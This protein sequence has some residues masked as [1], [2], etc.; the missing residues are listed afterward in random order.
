MS[1]LDAT[2]AERIFKKVLSIAGN[3]HAFVERLKGLPVYKLRI[4]DWRAIIAIDDK[5]QAIT[6]VHIGHRKNVYDD[7][8]ALE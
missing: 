4:G 1:A 3:P 7:L 2:V 5:K 8:E 6:V